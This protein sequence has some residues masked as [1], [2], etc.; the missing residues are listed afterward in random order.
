MRPPELG[1]KLCSRRSISM[2]SRLVPTVVRTPCGRPTRMENWVRSLVGGKLPR[3]R[4]DEATSE[5]SETPAPPLPP[6]PWWQS[7]TES[8]SALVARTRRGVAPSQAGS[9]ASLLH[10]DA[11][12]L[13][14]VP[15]CVPRAYRGPSARRAAPL[16]NSGC[17]P[18]PPPRVIQAECLSWGR[19]R[20]QRRRGGNRKKAWIVLR[21]VRTA[22]CALSFPDTS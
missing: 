10:D 12:L 9:H 14:D 16:G 6:R 20:R 1:G 3:T 2:S 18:L 13:I 11:A 7:R 22:Q 19:Q 5:A 15:S 21:A 4:G 8:R 17:R